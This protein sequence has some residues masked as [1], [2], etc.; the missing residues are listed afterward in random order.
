MSDNHRRAGWAK[1]AIETFTKE[2]F[3]GRRFDA[4]VREDQQDAISDLMCDLQHLAHQRGLGNDLL[5]RAA[6]NFTEELAEEAVDSS[7]AVG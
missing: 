6:R 5:E 7:E 2:V 4:L 3:A 1:N